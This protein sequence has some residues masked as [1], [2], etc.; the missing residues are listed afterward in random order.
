MYLLENGTKA[1][2]D[3]AQEQRKLNRI[4]AVRKA[5]LKNS[6][7]RTAEDEETLYIKDLF[8]GLSETFFPNTAK[9]LSCTEKVLSNTAEALPG[10]ARALPDTAETLSD[11]AKRSGKRAAADT[12]EGFV[13]GIFLKAVTEEGDKIVF[14]AEADVVDFVR[15]LTL[16]IDV[17]EIGEDR[18]VCGLLFQGEPYFA[19]APSRVAYAEEKVP[20]AVLKDKECGVHLTAHWVTEAG[21]SRTKEKDYDLG[22]VTDS[23]VASVRIEHPSW[24]RK[25]PHGESDPVIVCYNRK[26]SWKD[27]YDYL[28][29]FRDAGFYIPSK[30]NAVFRDKSMAFDHAVTTGEPGSA[31]C[32]MI[33]R[34]DGGGVVY[35][36]NTKKADFA[37]FFTMYKDPK[38]G[39][40]GFQWDFKNVEWVDHNPLPSNVVF[41]ADYDLTVDFYVKN[42][43][44]RHTMTIYSGNTLPGSSRKMSGLQIYWGCLYKDTRI[45]MADGTVRMIQ[46]IRA[47]EEV[48]TKDGSLLVRELVTGKELRAMCRITAGRPEEERKKEL[49][50]TTEHPVV[51]DQGVKTIEDLT[52]HAGEGGENIYGEKIASEDGGYDPICAVDLVAVNDNTVYNLVLENRDHTLPDPEAAVFYAEGLLVGDNNLQAKVMKDRMEQ[53]KREH[54]LPRSWEKDVNSAKKYF[55][56]CGEEDIIWQD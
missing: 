6:R 21:E 30:G 16:T 52:F 50:L 2:S 29:Y 51:T 7:V 37:K 39:M 36:H 31:S 56:V 19:F 23:P 40:P 13:D 24:Q 55:H 15:Q 45:T 9:A 46:D 26:P 32:M 12:Q 41:Q 10:T 22:D 8:G 49:Y 5:S 33:V 28:L 54:G 3:A 53:L 11:T 17:Y 18:E 44:R 1:G 34:R 35:F 20:E 4:R 27:E 43:S 38:T 25:I 42:S 47:G 14:D 48:K